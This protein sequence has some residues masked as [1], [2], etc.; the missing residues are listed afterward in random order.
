MAE[1]W[2]SAEWIELAVCIVVILGAHV[3]SRS[4]KLRNSLPLPPGKL[5]W[6]FWDDTK[7]FLRSLTVPT[8]VGKWIEERRARYGN[9]FKA[10]V[11]F[12]L[13]VFALGPEANR[14]VLSNDTKFFRSSWPKSFRELCGNSCIVVAS[15]EQHR[16]LRVHVEQFLATDAV[17]RFLST[18]EGCILRCLDSWQDGDVVHVYPEMHLLAFTIGYKFILGGSKDVDFDKL[19]E[20]YHVL[21]SNVLCFTINLPWTRYGKAMRARN[22][23]H[24]VVYAEIRKRRAEW[25]SGV[26]PFGKDRLSSRNIQLARDLLDLFTFW[27]V[28][29]ESGKEWEFTEDEI[30]QNVIVMLL[31]S[32]VT[33]SSALTAAVKCLATRPDIVQELREECRSVAESKNSNK[34]ITWVDTKKLQYARKVIYEAVRLHAP[35]S[36]LNKQALSDLEFAGCRIPKDWVVVLFAGE[37]HTKEE[38]FPSPEV[39]NPD[40]FNEKIDLYSFIPFGRGARMCPGEKFATVLMQIFLYHLVQRFEF[41]LV[42]PEEKFVMLLGR[43]NTDLPVKLKSIREMSE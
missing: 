5:A 26:S 27:E 3:L 12:R 20:H 36:Q 1:G 24:E 37:T 15:G 11:F 29:P 7:D 9:L 19:Q 30:A 4:L 8:E 31:A 22:A 18:I 16:R 41:E 6:F 40:R 13:N 14:F 34:P 35:T 33:T 42:R 17:K 23:I 32:H 39:F 21:T 28:S 25:N 38:N 43:P 2:G 10:R